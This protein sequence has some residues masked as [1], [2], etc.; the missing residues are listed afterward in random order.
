MGR[1][2]ME[3]EFSEKL[4]QREIRPSASSWDRLDAM[5]TVAEQKKPERNRKWL[6]MAASFIGIA[7]MTTFFFNAD[8]KID[9]TNKIAV[10]QLPTINNNDLPETTIVTDVAEVDLSDENQNK[11]EQQYPVVQA[12]ERTLHAV[13]QNQI[14]VPRSEK[15]I[16]NSKPEIINQKTD[17][18]KTDELLATVQPNV[19]KA[20]ATVKVDA[21]NL[22]SQV[23][24]EVELTFR[25]KI[26]RKVGKKYQNVKV[27]LANRNIED[28]NH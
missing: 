15:E 1:N 5:L 22:L 9:E 20:R 12:N 17:V 2:K 24:G 16:I 23:D 8:P 27:A 3:K 10:E 6:Y 26:I 21:K 19:P 18:V 28:E 25:E 14:V 7:M 13:A 11:T 4:S